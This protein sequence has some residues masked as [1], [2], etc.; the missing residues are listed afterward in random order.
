MHYLAGSVIRHH[1]KSLEWAKAEIYP[2]MRA[3]QGSADWYC[4]ISDTASWG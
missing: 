4:L 1:G 3:K 2:L